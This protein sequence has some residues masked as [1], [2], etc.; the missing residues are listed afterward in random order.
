LPWSNIDAYY[1]ERINAKSVS[2]FLWIDT[3]IIGESISIDLTLVEDN[4][5]NISNAIQENSKNW[6]I[7]YSGI[8][9]Y[10]S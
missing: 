8:H 9:K 6:S 10:K 1:F 2:Y 4:C 3:N 5:A 7:R